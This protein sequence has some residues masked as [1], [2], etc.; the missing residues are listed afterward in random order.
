MKVCSGCGISIQTEDKQM[1]G[2]APQRALERERVICQRC[3]RITHYNE[4]ASV[5]LDNKDYRAI[6]NDISNHDALVIMCIDLFDVAGSWVKGIDQAIGDNSILLVANKMDLFPLS[7]TI[8]KIE[9]WL[10]KEARSRGL[11]PV[12]IVVISAKKG[13]EFDQLIG[14]IE[15][16]REGKNVFVVGSANVGKSTMINRLIKDFGEGLDHELTTSPYPGTTL[17]TVHIP[18]EDGKELIDTPGIIN[19]QQMSHLIAPEE[20]PLITPTKPIDPIVY[21]LNEQ[22]TL[23]IG[24]LV[25]IDFIKGERQSFVFYVANQ[26]NLHRTKLENA[27]TLYENHK[28]ELLAPPSMDTLENFPPFVTHTIRIKN[29]EEKDIVISG[30]GWVAVKGTGALIEVQAPKGVHIGIRPSLI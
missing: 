29:G 28:G 14:M 10:R 21:Q 18:L 3:F 30:L 22:Q 20:I 4:I 6:L 7:I 1:P 13:Y 23:F 26:L 15:Q 9:D 12:D 19:E 8:E 16:Y 25:R 24:G 2:F 27:D 17:Q 11:K 5:S